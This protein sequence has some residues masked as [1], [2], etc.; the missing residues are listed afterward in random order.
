MANEPNTLR[1]E[2]TAD[3]LRIVRQCINEIANGVKLSSGEMQARMGCTHD[4]VR[5]LVTLLR[6]A[7]DHRGPVEIHVHAAAPPGTTG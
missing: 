5:T 7:R 1:F 2:I 6:P 3:Q 4:E